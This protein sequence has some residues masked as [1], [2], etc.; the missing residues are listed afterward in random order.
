M[1]DDGVS[2]VLERTETTERRTKLMRGK[3]HAF[4]ISFLGLLAGLSAAT[5]FGILAGLWGLVV[6]LIIASAI[7]SFVRK[8]RGTVR[9]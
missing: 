5:K 9:S 2:E 4:T 1:I 7:T 6:V 3:V 8:R